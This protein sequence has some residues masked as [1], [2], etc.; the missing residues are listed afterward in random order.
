MALTEQQRL[1]IGTR[2]AQSHER[3]AQAAQRDRDQRTADQH[4]DEAARWDRWA[5]GFDVDHDQADS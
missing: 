4:W 3:A 5:L 1:E 2:R